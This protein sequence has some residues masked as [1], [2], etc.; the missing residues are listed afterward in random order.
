MMRPA[1]IIVG[2]GTTPRSI[3]RRKSESAATATLARAAEPKG[4]S[5][6]SPSAG[7]AMSKNEIRRREREQQ[8]LEQRIE[9]IEARIAEIEAT[10]GDPALYAAGADPARPAALAAERDKLSAELAEAYATW[11]RV[12][13]ELAGV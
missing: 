5:A 4:A 11:E 13:E 1:L 6:G 2:P 7:G 9:K 3:A 10:L 8:A 12:G